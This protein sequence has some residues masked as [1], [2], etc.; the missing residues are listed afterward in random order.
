MAHMGM[1]R[2]FRFP[3][4]PTAMQ[5]LL[6]GRMLATHR[7]VYNEAVEQRRGAYRRNRMSVTYWDQSA[8][9]KVL[10]MESGWAR[11]CNFSSLQATLKRVDRAFQAFFR[12]VKKGGKPGYPRYKGP[13]RFNCVEFPT[14]GDGIKLLEDGFKVRIRNIGTIKVRRYRNIKGSVKTLSI[15]RDDDKWF[16]VVSCDLGAAPAVCSTNPPVGIDVGLTTFAMTDQGEAIE[17]P[18]FFKKAK[19]AIRRASRK[20][21]RRTKRDENR[22]LVGRQSKRRGKAKR[23]LRKVHRKVR[24]QRRDFVHKEARKIV[25][26]FGLI[27]MED[28]TIKNMVRN[29]R[30]AGSISDASWGAFKGAVRHGAEEA[31]VAFVGVD[32]RGTSQDCSG[33][34]REV[35]KGLKVRVHACPYCGLVLDRD[36][37]AAR[38]ILSRAKARTVPAG[39]VGGVDNLGLLRGDMACPPLPRGRLGSPRL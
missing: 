5:L 7:H 15:V 30:L 22:K 37:N 33:C 26:R 35:R 24:E 25:S 8:W 27:A 10:R 23:E 19:P 16:L 29:H 20:L 18:R 28:L 6:L 39:G 2:S 1:R 17:N 13:D 3:L 21:E 12:R 11:A 34:G 32:P 4:M 31:G 36:V 9:L 14:P 38:N